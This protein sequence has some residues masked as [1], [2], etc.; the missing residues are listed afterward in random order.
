M[1]PPSPPQNEIH[2][3]PNKPPGRY[4]KRIHACSMCEKAFDRPSTLKKHMLVHTGE[5]SHVCEICGRRFSVAS[6]LNRHVR[7]CV[8]R[9]VNTMH[10]A[11]TSSGQPTLADTSS[12]G[13]SVTVRSGSEGCSTGTLSETTLSPRSSAPSPKRTSTSDL[14]GEADASRPAKKRPR[15]A[16]TPT[17]W[18]PVSLRGFDLTP[19]RK[20]CPIPLAPVRPSPWDGE[21]RNS[22][23]L[24]ELPHNPYHPE[25][26]VGKLPGPACRPIH[27][28]MMVQ[29]IELY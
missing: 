28:G 21:E 6:N 3:L 8:L 13:S 20:S 11:A 12:A 10:N 9:P 19:S 15:R 7:R 29:R 16:P 22:Y 4:R 1:R 25:G 23:S 17:P 5:K 14:N 18:V 26:W 27:T 2:S 24:D